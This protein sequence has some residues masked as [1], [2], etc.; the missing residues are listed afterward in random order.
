MEVISLSANAEPR[1]VRLINPL[2]KCYEEID[3]GPLSGLLRGNGE[4]GSRRLKL[5]KWITLPS[6]YR[7]L[8]LG[9][10]VK[11]PWFYK[12]PINSGNMDF[13]K[14]HW[15]TWSTWSDWRRDAPCEAVEALLKGWPVRLGYGLRNK[16]SY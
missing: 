9:L 12:L 11:T 6:Y 10:S 2:T 3:L 8:A 14:R 13:T 16:I 15:S 5:S 4:I 1:V 7:Q